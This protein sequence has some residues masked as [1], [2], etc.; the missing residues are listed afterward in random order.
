MVSHGENVNIR[1]DVHLELVDEVEPLKQ[2]ADGRLN[3]DTGERKEVAE[4]LE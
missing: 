3:F 2:V 4:G 1:L